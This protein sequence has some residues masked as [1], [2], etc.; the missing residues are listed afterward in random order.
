M[1]IISGRLPRVEKA[2]MPRTR[3][4]ITEHEPDPSWRDRAACRGTDPELFFPY[5]EAALLQIEDAI[6]VCRRCPVVTR[7]LRWALD[8]GENDGI[9]GGTTAEQRRKMRRNAVRKSRAAGED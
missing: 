5:S 2:A 4:I 8:V 9:W 6:D 7:C 3:R 1:T